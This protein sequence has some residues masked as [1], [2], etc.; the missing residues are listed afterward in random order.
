MADAAPGVRRPDWRPVRSR[1][2][3]RGLIAHMP[4]QRVYQEPACRK[5]IQTFA[6]SARLGGEFFREDFGLVVCDFAYREV[7]VG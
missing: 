7:Q 2:N 3:G 6:D 4:L 1:Q 5:L